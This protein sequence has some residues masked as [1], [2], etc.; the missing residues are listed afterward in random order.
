M[1]STLLHFMSQSATGKVDWVCGNLMKKKILPLT[2]LL[3]I[4]GRGDFLNSNLLE[5][6]ISYKDME[7]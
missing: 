2:L 4:L 3:V 6:V 1:V 5:T 7:E